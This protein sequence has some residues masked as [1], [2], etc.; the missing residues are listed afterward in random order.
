[1]RGVKLIGVVLAI[2]AGTSAFLAAGEVKPA[3]ANPVLVFDTLKGSFEIEL[4]QSET[5]KSVE[6]IL[7]LMKRN[8]Y[9]AQRFHRVTPN[10]VQFGDP[11]TRD[12]TKEASWG[13][14]NSGRVIGVFELSKKR[15]NVRGAVGLGHS[16]NPAYADSQMYILKTNQTANDGKY[17]II[18]QVTKGMAVIDKLVRTDII[19]D[20]RVQ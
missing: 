16:G 4:F 12:M 5:P 2:V 10:L 13:S 19:K 6:H 18:G 17:A 9:R 1:M 11:Q 3:P 7:D 15:S 20:A 14:G 8:F